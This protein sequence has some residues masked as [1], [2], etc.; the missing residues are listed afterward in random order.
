MSWY[1]FTL[2]NF[3]I[4]LNIHFF[5]FFFLDR[6]TWHFICRK[7]KKVYIWF[8]FFSIKMLS[9]QILEVFFF[10]ILF[11]FVLYSSMIPVHYCS[12]FSKIS[13]LTFIITFFPTSFAMGCWWIRIHYE[14][15]LHELNPCIYSFMKSHLY[16]SVQPGKMI[17]DKIMF[18]TRKLNLL[19]SVN[20]SL[21]KIQCTNTFALQ[22]Q[23][24][25]LDY[26][27]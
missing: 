27:S 21:S 1:Q 17:S 11:A 16:P 20:N 7:W 24:F 3:S 4:L 8:N 15:S 5:F 10:S 18:H 22:E 19:F 26:A 13:K 9:K 6:K 12:L 14:Q 23:D 2:P 25:Q